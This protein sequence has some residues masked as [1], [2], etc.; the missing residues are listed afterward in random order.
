MWWD[1]VGASLN[2]TSRC[3]RHPRV[4]QPLFGSESTLESLSL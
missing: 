2:K 4:S 3:Q 1:V